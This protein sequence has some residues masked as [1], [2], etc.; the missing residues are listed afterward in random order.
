MSCAQQ[1]HIFYRRLDAERL[2]YNKVEIYPYDEEAV[3]LA[4]AEERRCVS[5]ALIERRRGNRAL[6]ERRRVRHICTDKSVK[7]ALI[8]RRR[9]AHRL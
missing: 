9:I 4:S 3:R 8:E 5:H 2:S 7:H 6:I 1:A